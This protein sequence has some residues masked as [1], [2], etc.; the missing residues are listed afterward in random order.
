[1]EKTFKDQANYLRFKDRK[2]EAS[3]NVKRKIEVLEVDC[4]NGLRFGNDR[5]TYAA[6]K[7]ITRRIQ[8]RK[9][10]RGWNEY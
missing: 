2:N 1:M 9:L 6:S 3:T 10:N 8:R 4:C 5:K 7:V